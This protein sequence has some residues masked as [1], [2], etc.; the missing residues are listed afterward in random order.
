M[1]TAAPKSPTKAKYIYYEDED[2]GDDEAADP[3][4]TLNRLNREIEV[5]CVLLGACVF[6][7]WRVNCAIFVAPRAN[8]R[9]FIH[10]DSF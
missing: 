6:P 5:R 7:E 9:S 8:D 1:A 3:L 10:Q 4:A 2:D